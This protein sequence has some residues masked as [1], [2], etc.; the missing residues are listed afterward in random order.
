MLPTSWKEPVVDDQTH[1][2]TWTCSEVVKQQNS[3]QWW[4]Q[5]YHQVHRIIRSTIRPRCTELSP[6]PRWFLLLRPVVDAPP[7]GPS[8]DAPAGLSFTTI[9]NTQMISF[10]HLPPCCSVP[11]HHLYVSVSDSR[12]AWA[13]AALRL[14][15]LGL[16]TRGRRSGQSLD[17]TYVNPVVCSD[18][19][20]LACRKSM[21][22]LLKMS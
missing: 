17:E 12:S 10:S 1:Q 11:I 16:S 7:K 15:L 5:R 21:F 9:S 18:F 22:D 6:G 3:S 8:I 2:P 13:C 14:S 20:C 19:L 4:P